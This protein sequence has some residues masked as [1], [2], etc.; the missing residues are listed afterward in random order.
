MNPFQQH[1]AF[2]WCELMTPDPAAAQAFY[3][4]LLGWDFKAGDVE[5]TLY[6]TISVAGKEVGGIASLPASSPGMPPAWGLYITVEDVDAIAE[7]AQTL[8]GKI[9]MPAMDIPQV[10][11]FALL[12]DPQGATFCAISYVAFPD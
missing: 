1:G 9:L 7:Q 2:S 12:Q 8:G 10:G 3:G 6:T 5:G 11:R 4:P